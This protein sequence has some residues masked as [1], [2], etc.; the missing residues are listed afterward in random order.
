MAAALCVA[1]IYHPVLVILI[2]SYIC[3]GFTPGAKPGES[4]GAGT[5]ANAI[6]VPVKAPSID[7]SLDPDKEERRRRKAQKKEEKRLK[8]EKKRDSKGKCSCILRFELM[9]GSGTI[10]WV[11]WVFSVPNLRFRRLPREL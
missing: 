6:A 5:G 2:V 7:G 1:C 4:A 10:R 11:H 8:K 9:A 3:R